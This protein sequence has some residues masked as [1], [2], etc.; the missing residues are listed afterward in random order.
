MFFTLSAYQTN[1]DVQVVRN[2]SSPTTL[3]ATIHY[4]SFAPR[5]H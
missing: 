4:V 3:V 1:A 5:G 2:S